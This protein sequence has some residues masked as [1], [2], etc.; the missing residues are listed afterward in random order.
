MGDKVTSWG[1]LV[2]WFRPVVDPTTWRRFAYL[3]STFPLGQFWFIISVTLLSLGFGMLVIIVGVPILAGLVLLW[4]A[5]AMMERSLA[6]ALGDTEIA[7][8][9]RPAPGNGAIKTARAYLSDPATVRDALW[10]FLLFPLGIVWFT[11]LAVVWSASLGMAVAPLWYWTD[12][13]Q[14]GLWEVDSFPGAAVASLIGIALL[15]VAARVTRAAGDIHG[16]LA[17]G[18]LGPTRARALE[19]EV[20]TL[21]V[22]S[23]KTVDVAEMERRRIERDLHDGAQQRLVAL[24]M[25]L[26]RA[27][28]K[29]DED[30]DGARRLIDDAHGNAKLALEELRDLARGIHPAVLADRGL[31]P[32]LSALAARS[33]IPVQIT[34]LL[35]RRP[36]MS[37]ESAAYFVVSEALANAGKHS[38]AS[39]VAVTVEEVDN[40]V[41]VEVMDDGVGG[42]IATGSGLSGLADRVEAMGGRL[43][44]LSPVGGPSLVRAEIPCG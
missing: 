24:A 2:R 10:L 26:G 37:V 25:E 12:G 19:G 36:P 30:P 32:A 44:V 33:P 27:K 15:P 31:D 16:R 20:R 29:F 40:S 5:G 9:Y 3:L 42:A 41:V 35:D 18:M 17:A 22:R 38:L 28:A 39:I 7:V 6:D 34:F 13:V 4:R 14:I 8:P 23:Q 21:E 1:A 43:A 11:F